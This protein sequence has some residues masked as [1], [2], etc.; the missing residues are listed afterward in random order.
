MMDLSPKG[1][2][3]LLEVN[4]VAKNRLFLVSGILIFSAMMISGCSRPPSESES[5]VQVGQPAPK[6]KLRDLNGKEITLD[7]YKGRVV[8]L[9]FWATWCNPCRMTMPIFERLQKEYSSTLVL[10]A[11]NL[12]EPK[13]TVQ[14]YVYSQG[15]HSQV[16]LDEEGSVGMAYG[17]ESI[18]MEVLVDKQ[19]IVRQVHMGYDPRSTISKLRAEIEQLR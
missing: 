3:W 18:P 1:R 19:G 9:D 15:I 10:L 16:L 6:F 2:P 8:L 4:R 11:I 13:E 7:Q 12:Q 14:E 5:S 17:T